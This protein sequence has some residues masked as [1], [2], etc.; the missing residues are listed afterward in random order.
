MVVRPRAN[1]QKQQKTVFV[2]GR[3]A[4]NDKNSRSPVDEH[5]KI[6]K[7]AVRPRTNNRKQKKQGFVHGRTHH[8]IN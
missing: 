6:T 2:H 1:N 7:T 8:F 3:K 5:I 4:E